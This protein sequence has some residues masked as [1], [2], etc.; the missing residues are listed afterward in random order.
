[1]CNVYVILESW[2][3]RNRD[4]DRERGSERKKTKRTNEKEIENGIEV[5]TRFMAECLSLKTFCASD[6]YESGSS[7]SSCK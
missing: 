7:C 6:V 2:I 5:D 4:R 1:M 3:D